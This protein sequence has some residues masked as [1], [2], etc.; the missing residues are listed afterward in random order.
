MEQKRYN[1][2][3]LLAPVG[4][5]E[6]L[7]SAVR[8]GADAVYLAGKSFGMRSA[9]SNFTNE[10]LEEAVKFMHEPG[11]ENYSVV[12]TNGGYRLIS[13]M[14]AKSEINKIISFKDRKEEF[15]SRISEQGNLRKMDIKPQE[16]TE[17]KI[18]NIQDRYAAA[19]RY[20]EEQEII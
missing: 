11:N 14:E 18:Y 1:A 13:D 4:D 5:M 17:N 10:E 8:Y 2:P 9:P 15:A 12:E 19:E 7:I 16:R 6:R 20:A 3:E